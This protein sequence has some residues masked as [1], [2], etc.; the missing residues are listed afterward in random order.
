ME[1]PGISEGDCRR[2]M[3]MAEEGQY[4]SKVFNGIRYHLYQTC[5]SKERARELARRLRR[6]DPSFY[7]N[8]SFRIV[9]ILRHKYYRFPVDENRNPPKKKEFG[10]Y[11]GPR[12]EP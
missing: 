10:L 2:K 8:R 3:T 9:P 7:K 12:R 11:I 6:T 1:R 5:H 4:N